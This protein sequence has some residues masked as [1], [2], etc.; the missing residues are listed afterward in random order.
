MSPRWALLLPT[1]THLPQGVLQ[2]GRAGAPNEHQMGPAHQID[3][4]ARSVALGLP[5]EQK[6]PAGSPSLPAAQVGGEVGPS[7]CGD[8]PDS[9]GRQ[10][11]VGRRAHLHGR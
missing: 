5:W 10:L 2:E 1:S 7:S 9:A 4:K 8:I 6:W 3:I 11:Q